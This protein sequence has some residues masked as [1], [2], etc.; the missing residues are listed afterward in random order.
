MTADHLH[1]V[2]E[3]DEK[4]GFYHWEKR[5]KQKL[6]V[7]VDITLDI[8]RAARTDD[9]ADTIDYDIVDRLIQD[10]LKKR[11]Y[12]LIETIA[13]DVASHLLNHWPK[14]RV[15]ITV[16]KPFAIPHAKKISAS[17]YRTARSYSTGCLKPGK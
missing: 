2:F 5:R 15:W 12:H 10:L 11:H 8:K 17:I 3:Y 16:D 4:L 6:I 9:L 1:L 14:S 13:E 7:T